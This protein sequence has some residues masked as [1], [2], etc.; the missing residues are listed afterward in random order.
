MQKIITILIG[1]SLSVSV[2]AQM[3][4]GSL[5][6]SYFSIL[7]P[8]D[9]DQYADVELLYTDID[10]Q[11]D[12][13]NALKKAVYHDLFPNASIALDPTREANFHD[14]ETLLGYHFGRLITPNYKR[15][16]KKEF[17][18]ML[19]PVSKS[20]AFSLVQEQNLR[21]GE[22]TD[23]SDV[24]FSGADGF[25][26]VDA[27]YSELKKNHYDTSDIPDQDIIYGAAAGIAKAYNDPYTTFLK[28]AE[29]E[30]FDSEIS[31]D[32]V[33]IGAYVHVN[34]SGEFIVTGTIDGSSA[35]MAGLLSDDRI[36]RV[37]DFEI[38][39]YSNISDIV[40]RIKGPEGSSVTLGIQR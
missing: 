13:G 24:G 21:L 17:A 35:Q 12:V 39:A 36:V 33:G 5:L 1:V 38:P 26:I 3:T 11:S 37:D 19:L 23:T 34:S 14:A 28:P 7:L 29:K 20:Y 15:I 27:V 4:F 2:F 25:D 8:L 40:D 6:E 18:E 9:Q 32:Y 10:P 22:H 16:S 30:E 31:G